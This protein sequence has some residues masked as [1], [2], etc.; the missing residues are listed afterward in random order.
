M[1]KILLVLLAVF[2]L[3][4]C[5]Q[6]EGDKEMSLLVLG[7][8][9]DHKLSIFHEGNRFYQGSPKVDPSTNISY[10]EIIMV[11][12][13]DEIAIELDGKNESSMKASLKIL[14]D[15]TMNCVVIEKKQGWSIEGLQERPLLD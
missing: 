10:S 12:I 7:D 13:G 3:T 6:P 1:Y 9:S 5:Y 4:S 14:I 8:V 11:S 15:A 2:A